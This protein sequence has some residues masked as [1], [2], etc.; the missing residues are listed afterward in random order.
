[1]SEHKSLG[2]P[3]LTNT[4]FGSWERVIRGYCM[5]HSLVKFL[6]T[7]VAP[8]DEAALATYN[9]NRTRTAGILT[10]FMGDENFNRLKATQPPLDKDDPA[11]I[12]K[13]LTDRYQANTVQNKSKVY[14]EYNIFTFKKDLSTF[15]KDLDK[16][17]SL[18][19]SVGFV[20][21]EPIGANIRESIFAESIVGKLPVEFEN[22]RELL[23]NKRPLTI[24][25]VRNALENKER[26]YVIIVD[27]D[28]QKR[29]HCAYRRQ[30]IKQSR[31]PT[32]QA[33]KTQSSYQS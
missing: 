33:G 18:L 26:E 22:T 11:V 6:N 8:A 1:M 21:G 31:L 15:N 10:Q 24:Q 29:R 3:T 4:S 32:L 20:I 28:H 5:Q 9:N 19:S 30:I 27:T 23:W 7:T 12:W 16:H 25:M 2:I 17:L 14:H 13:F